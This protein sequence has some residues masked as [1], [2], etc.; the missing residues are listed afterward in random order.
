MRAV[1]PLAVVR[2]VCAI[3]I[4]YQLLD[5]RLLRVYVEFTPVI[6]PAWSR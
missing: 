2:K 4:N 6:D 1:L 3:V 5:F